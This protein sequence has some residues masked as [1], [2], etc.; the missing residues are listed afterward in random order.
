MLRLEIKSIYKFG[1]NPEGIYEYLEKI[2]NEEKIIA[3]TGEFSSGKSSFTNAFIG[4]ENFLPQ[5]N[6]ECTPVLLDLVSSQE[7]L[8]T[9]KYKD[10]T[11]RNVEM[12]AENIEHYA[13]NHDGYD[14]NILSVAVPV[15]SKYLSE[16]T[17]FIDT[18]GTNTVIAEQEE[19]TNYILKK[20]DVVL[21]VI[22]KALTQY[23][24]DKI[25]EIRK[26]TDQ[27]AFIIT[28][29]DEEVSGIYQNR[30]ES[31]IQNFLNE[32]S[33]ELERKLEI[34]DA[35]ILP[36]GSLASYTDNKYIEEIRCVVKEYI[37]LNSRNVI[38]NR[39]KRQLEVIF[40][41]KYNE[42]N[43]SIDM[44]KEAYET[45]GKELQGK[46]DALSQKIKR[47]E[48]SNENKVETLQEMYGQVSEAL[49]IRINHLFVEEKNRILR[50]IL[51]N[52]NITQ[53]EIEK[54]FEESTFNI[55]NSLKLLTEESIEAL[56][57][58]VYE[59]KKEELSALS[60]EFSINLNIKVPD[61]ES[62]NDVEVVDT[63]IESIKS[64]SF[65]KK[66]ELENI[67]EELAVGMEEMDYINREYEWVRKNESIARQDMNKLGNYKPE[68]ENKVI[69]ESG[70]KSG[71]A[72]GRIAGEIADIA[73]MVYNP[74]VGISVLSQALMVKDGAKI[75][76]YIG[77]SIELAKNK[78]KQRDNKYEYG[79][80]NKFLKALD[81]LSIG[82]Y[83]AKAG[84]KIGETIKPL[85][86]ILVE[87]E[88]KRAE[89]ESKRDEI[90]DSIV[91]IK[92]QRSELEYNIANNRMQ[93]SEARRRK[94]EIEEELVRLKS[95]EKDISER[96]AQEK[97]RK[98]TE[99][100]TKYYKEEISNLM[101]NEHCK[102]E[103]TA[104]SIL[105]LSLRDIISKSEED[106]DLKIQSIKETLFMTKEEKEKIKVAI[107]EKN[108]LL[109]ELAP[110][111]EW[112]E[113]WIENECS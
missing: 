34:K 95:I 107:E 97:E 81:L 29:M 68:Y 52:K 110:Y 9:I 111:K 36:V 93:L 66:M 41:N 75:T 73:L 72:V 105:A 77:E 27:I 67:Q 24:I 62:F 98:S 59:N 37:E 14:S 1:L 19:I 2:K 7:K 17:H 12:T 79:N 20:A 61:L 42:I 30:S 48:E 63:R 11:I 51:E 50:L 21:Y 56:I 40:E 44:L 102:A 104:L 58:L 86:T 33:K 5:A 38:K 84:E 6:K 112:I 3:V 39:V 22:N 69:Q 18:P 87:N 109:N 53:M 91:A 57:G 89:W 25:K 28:H 106:F 54:I 32:A 101:N 13:A 8:M 26:F 80:K 45:D 76:Q 43:E 10:G 55:S 4:E 90:A 100:I 71:K 83:A 82:H 108:D 60:Q 74:V 46:I 47:L 96:L 35:D 113:E 16:N 64:Q 99:M 15:E 94:R 49:K 103:E 31:E 78:T 23:D 88:E 70:G 92:N 85:K 65:N